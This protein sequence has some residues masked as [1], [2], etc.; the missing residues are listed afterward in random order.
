MKHTDMSADTTGAQENPSENKVYAILLVSGDVT[1]MLSM[2]DGSPF[3][4]KDLSELA[5]MVF[6]AGSVAFGA[7]V[8]PVMVVGSEYLCGIDVWHPDDRLKFQ[9]ELLVIARANGDVESTRCVL[10]AMNDPVPPEKLR[11]RIPLA[12]CR[13]H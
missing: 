2:V 8:T 6:G 11:Y 4:T 7:T 13:L 12:S 1:V 9:L 3:V 10:D 5:L